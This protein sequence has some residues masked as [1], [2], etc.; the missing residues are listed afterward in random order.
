MDTANQFF[1]KDNLILS[2]QRLEGHIDYIHFSDNRGFRVEHLV[3]GEGS[4][5]WDSFFEILDKI[6][7]NGLLGIDI[8]GAESDIS[9]YDH[10]YRKTA[11]WF[12]DNWLNTKTDES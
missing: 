7:Y 10:A 12:Y 4:I 6:K 3:P 2:L 8:G 9:D 1:L 5:P 11:S